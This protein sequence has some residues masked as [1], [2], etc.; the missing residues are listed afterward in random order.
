[1]LINCSNSLGSN[2]S[3]VVV[4][5][6]HCY[7][8]R[9]YTSWLDMFEWKKKEEKK[10]YHKGIVIK[11]V[12]YFDKILLIMISSMISTAI[13]S[14]G[15]F[16]WSSCLKSHVLWTWTNLILWSTDL[17]STTVK[18]DTKKQWCIFSTVAAV[19]PC[20]CV[21]VCVWCASNTIL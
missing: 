17:H 11:Y 4:W 3:C 18:S 20:M 2:L 19:C 13:Y 1:M 9:Y 6:L 5:L 16:V 7:Q 10:G 14:W 12:L 8:L 21:C 15:S